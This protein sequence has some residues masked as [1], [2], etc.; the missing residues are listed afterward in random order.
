MWAVCNDFLSQ[1]SVDGEEKNNQKNL[2]NYVMEGVLVIN[3]PN[4]LHHLFSLPHFTDEK[5]EGD[6]FKGHM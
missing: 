5:T 1:S 6:V 2:T 4:S 3:E